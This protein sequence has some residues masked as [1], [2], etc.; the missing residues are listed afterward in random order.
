[1]HGPIGIIE[2]FE[3]CC[4]NRMTVLP[5]PSLGETNSGHPHVPIAVL[6]GRHNRCWLNRVEPIQNPERM[7]SGSP[8][9]RCGCQLRQ[10]R[11]LTA[12]PA[13]YQQALCCVATP[14]V[15][16]CQRVDELP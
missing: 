6:E 3:Q 10:I 2:P 14:S 16:M 1:M 12:R 9:R 13:L 5:Q 11:D 8:I 7:E 4:L 15:R